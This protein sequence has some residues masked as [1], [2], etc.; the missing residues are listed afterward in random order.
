MDVIVELD[1][2]LASME[3]RRHLL[4]E[5]PALGW[6]NS[7]AGEEFYALG[8]EA[9]PN[10]PLIELITSAFLIQP[11]G[12]IIVSTG[13]PSIYKAKTLEWLYDA[14]LRIS[15]LIMRPGVQETTEARVKRN[16]LNRILQDGYTP[17]LIFER[18]LSDAAA[19]YRN[20]GYAV[21]TVTF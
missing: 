13:R 3:G 14:G 2:V 1:G 8:L 19:Y 10:G 18:E 15:T 21:V 16:N 11:D 4:P 17:E 20:L 9:K 12:N 6:V 7:E 5:K